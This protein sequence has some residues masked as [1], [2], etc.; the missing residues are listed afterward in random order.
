MI[1][2]CLGSLIFLFKRIGFRC[3]KRRSLLFCM[4]LLVIWIGKRPAGLLN[5]PDQNGI[6]KKRW[7][8]SKYMCKNMLIAIYIWRS[9]GMFPSLNLIVSSFIV[10]QH[11]YWLHGHHRLQRICCLFSTK[12]LNHHR[13]DEHIATPNSCLFFFL[14]FND[15]FLCFFF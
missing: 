5:A 10:F 6:W 4:L 11:H 2:L 15:Q 9:I 1:D 13:L 3:S 12:I 14:R 7:K 8:I